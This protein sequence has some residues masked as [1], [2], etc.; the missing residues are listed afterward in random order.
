[1]QLGDARELNVQVA[2]MLGN[3]LFHLRDYL[4]E[5]HVGAPFSYERRSNI[6][7]GGN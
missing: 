4:S 5:P 6:F 1:L 3:R 2:P 7:V